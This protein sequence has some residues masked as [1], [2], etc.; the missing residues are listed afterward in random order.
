MTIKEIARLS[1]VGVSTVSRVLNKRP[2]VNE[3][4]RGR[5][6]EVIERYGY[7]PNSN[8]KHLKQLSTDCVAV[9]V[10]G[11]NNLFFSG[12]LELL[13]KRIE[14]AGLRFLPHYIDENDD[15]AAAALRVYAERKVRGI[16]FMGGC[17]TDNGAMLSRLPIPCVYST[18]NAA[19]GY[20]PNVSSVSVDDRQ[21]AKK[22]IDYLFD[23]G[24]EN[25]VILSGETQGCN[26]AHQRYLG[27]LDSF[28][29][30]GKTLESS[31]VLVS[32]FSFSC[33][34]ERIKEYTGPDY[35]A[36]FAMSDTMAIGAARALMD[37]GKRVPEELIE[38]AKIDGAN[39]WQ[40]LF[41]VTIPCVM[42]SITICTFLSLTNGFKLFD[43]NMALN[44][45]QPFEFLADGNV[46]KTTEMLALNIYNTFYQNS[47][48]RGVGQAKAVI[49]FLLVAALGLI[50]LNATRKKEVQQ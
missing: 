45:G 6:M 39:G 23:C 19:E 18:V 29:E 33:A 41:H 20:A 2:D 32:P 4:T 24:H 10:R 40:T 9:I 5:V 8:A 11:R 22:A 21:G 43:Q 27:V 46:I 28:K 49:F 34:Y 50:Q 7:E 15:E 38:A 44:G 26:M 13:Q 30:H 35:T 14:A 42:P 37:S 25:M 48:S 31:R 3:D 17:H 47:N 36:I 16:I 1:G 12:I